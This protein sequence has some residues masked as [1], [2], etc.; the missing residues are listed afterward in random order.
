M[1]T[2]KDVARQACVSVSTVS[3]VLSGR[4]EGRITPEV[5]DRVRRAAADLGYVPNLLAK[6]LRTRQT[7]TIGLL[8]DSVASTP[9]A[10][11][12]LAAA[13]REAWEAGYLLLVID[14]A[15]EREMEVPA[16]QALLQRNVEGLI[17]AS[18]YHREVT[19]PPVPDDVPLVVMDGQPSDERRAD[20]IVPNEQEGAELAVGAL[21]Q[22]GH[23]RIAFCSNAERIPASVGRE[24]GYRSALAAAGI[25]YDPSLVVSAETNTAEAGQT[26]IH[27]LLSREI[28]AT[29]V[30]CFSDRIAIGA[31]R[32]AAAHGLNI[33]DD[34]SIV[35]FDNQQFV[36]DALYPG[37]TTIELPHAYMGT[38]AVRRLIERLRQPVD[39]RPTSS[40]LAP[41][42]LVIRE[43]IAPPKPPR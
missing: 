12:M 10:G 2:M 28:D 17:Y 41:C 42:R 6:G 38:W 7:H 3:L 11:M 25:D 23:R 27:E 24:R 13:Q 37:L 33:P 14:T 19:L 8:S 43:S 16:A 35:G 26:A 30:F 9:F 22:A 18:M 29:A 4:G 5:A 34:L 1:V 31:Y 15:A 32:A 40:E 20:W 39:D 21:V 36:A